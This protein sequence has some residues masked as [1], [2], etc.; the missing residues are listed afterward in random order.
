MRRTNLNL[1]F[2]AII[3]LLSSCFNEEDYNFSKIAE[4]EW[5]PS[6]AFKVMHG[7]LFLE[8][9]DDDLDGFEIKSYPDGLLYMHYESYNESDDIS[10]LIEFPEVEIETGLKSLI[11]LS[12]NLK[13]EITIIDRTITVDMKIKGAKLDSVFFDSFDL[14][15]LVG[16]TVNLAYEVSLDFPTLL[17]DGV[18]LSKKYTRQMNEPNII[19]D[20][21]HL[22][23]FL[24]VLDQA[25][26]PYNRF[27]VHITMKLLPANNITI[28]TDDIFV[29][30]LEITNQDFGWVKGYFIPD[31]RIVSDKELHVKIF[32]NNFKGDYSLAGTLMTYEIGNDFGV[33]IKLVFNK[34]ET[35]NSEGETLPIE[36]NPPSPF[37]IKSPAR[38]GETAYSTIQITNAAD[39]FNFRPNTFKYNI[40][41]FINDGYS[42]GRNFLADTSKARIKFIAEVPFWGH[43]GSILLRDT[44]QLNMGNLES[45]GIEIGTESA[46]LKTRVINGYPAD[47]AI[48]GILLNENFQ[49]IDSLLTAEQSVIVRSSLTND[50][51]IIEDGVFDEIIE[52][53]SDK[54]DALFDAKYMIILAV[55]NTYTDSDGTRPQVKF[56]DT[57]SIKVDMGLQTDLNVTVK[58]N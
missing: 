50:T 56:F 46:H 22:T 15:V 54:M 49:Y 12:G 47:V 53:D 24:A 35:A 19:E 27:P 44:V 5:D 2:G 16:S 17:V 6:Y 42:A 43:S 30:K 34:L 29:F 58:P 40:E 18:P 14:N 1:F 41:A 39:I 57:G 23:N 38:L 45:D 31:S 11:G 33:P 36:L 7:E 26:I 55:L 28:T 25:D 10:T 32:E 21:N 51:G 48:Q 52:L 37:E 9:F 4:V 13:K 3:F 8:D 20:F